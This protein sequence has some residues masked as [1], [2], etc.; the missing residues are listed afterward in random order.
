M[1]Q[2]MLRIK[3]I[4]KRQGED[5]EIIE[6]STE[7]RH[8]R[9][10]GADYLVYEESEISGMKGATT[11]LK[12]KD[13]AITLTR[14]GSTRTRMEFVR[15]KRFKTEYATSHG[16][17]GLEI[18]PHELYYILDENIRGNILIRYE[19]SLKGLSQSQNELRIDIF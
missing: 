17:F 8:Y 7:G 19:M 5:P 18:L 11:T 9:K 4:I 14:F 10:G 2:V 1:K 16:S 15:G 12:L 3:G 6:L 13:G